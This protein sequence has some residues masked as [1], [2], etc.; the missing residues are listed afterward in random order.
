MTF[1]PTKEL[2]IKPSRYMKLK[3]PENTFRMLADPITGYEWWEDTP[4]GKRTPVRRSED[5]G[6][7]LD[8]TIEEDTVKFFWAFPVWNYTD[9]AVQILELTQMSVIKA[10]RALWNSKKWGDPKNYDITITKTGD[11]LETRYAVMPEPPTKLDDMIVKLFKET[12]VNLEAL[13]AGEDPWEQKDLLKKPI[14]VE[15][16]GVDLSSI[17]FN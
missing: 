1:D 6:I 13:Y 3:N 2:P 12:P 4:D 11:K 10:V 14:T 7:A 15:D 5:E 16:D 17:P 9:Q 8:G